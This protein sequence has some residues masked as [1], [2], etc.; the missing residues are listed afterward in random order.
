MLDFLKD[1]LSATGAYAKRIGPKRGVVALAVIASA[2]GASI[3]VRYLKGRRA[4]PDSFVDD[5]RRGTPRT[6]RHGSN[7]VRAT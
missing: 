7:G 2:V 6:A 5:I 3:L 4:Q 1:K